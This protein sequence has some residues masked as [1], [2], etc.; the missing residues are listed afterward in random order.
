MVIFHV[1]HPY[2]SVDHLLHTICLIIFL[3]FI[4]VCRAVIVFNIKLNA[5]L[6]ISILFKSSSSHFPFGIHYF[7]NDLCSRYSLSQIGIV[8]SLFDD[9]TI[10]LQ[11]NWSKLHLWKLTCTLSITFSQC[12]SLH[13]IF[14]ADLRTVSAFN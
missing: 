10:N 3:V 13:S 14:L 11:T 4:I 8:V 5:S 6:A 1:S 2:K 12:G 7:F 9:I